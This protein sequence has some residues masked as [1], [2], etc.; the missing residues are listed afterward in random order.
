MRTILILL[1]VF[2]LGTLA[3]SL[4]SAGDCYGRCVG[5]TTLARVAV[6]VPVAVVAQVVEHRPVRTFFAERQPVRRTVRG[7][8]RAVAWPF[9][10]CR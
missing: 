5:T 4:A 9:R 1:A 7:V 8:A 2:L 10:G 6:A 3:C